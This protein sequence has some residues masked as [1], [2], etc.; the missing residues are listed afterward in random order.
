M[1]KSHRRPENTLTFRIPQ[2]AHHRR[3]PIVSMEAKYGI[4][5]GKGHLADSLRGFGYFGEGFFVSRTVRSRFRRHVSYVHDGFGG[6]ETN[7]LQQ[8][9]TKSKMK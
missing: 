1:I 8:V 7:L 4:G 6:Q 3:Y 9:K 2:A 5:M